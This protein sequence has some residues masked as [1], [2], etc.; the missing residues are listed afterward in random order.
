[1]SW[2]R[3]GEGARQEPSGS[4][5]TRANLSPAEKHNAPGIQAWDPTPIDAAP[6][7]PIHNRGRDPAEP[8]SAQSSR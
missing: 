6:R 2:Q 7:V 5:R 3:P 8:L 4:A 1:M